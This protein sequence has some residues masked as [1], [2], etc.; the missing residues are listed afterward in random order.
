MNGLTMQTNDVGDTSMEMGGA[1]YLGKGD[2][3]D[4]GNGIAGIEL[5]STSGR[6]KTYRISFTDG[7]HYDYTV[8]DGATGATGQDG[9]DGADGVSV[10][11]AEINAQG[12][13]IITLSNGQQIDAGQVSGGGGGATWG[14]IT[15]DISDQTDL[16]NALNDK[17]D[18]DKLPLVIVYGA[19]DVYDAVNAA[20]TAHVPVFAKRGINQYTIAEK[21]SNDVFRFTCAMANSSRILTM[22]LK[23]DN[24]WSTAVEYLQQTSSTALITTDTTIVG[25]INEVATA[26]AD[27]PTIKTVMDAV[28]MT[29]TQYFLGT[30][31]AV[32]ITLPS[33]GISVGDEILVVFTSGATAATLICDLTGFDFTPKANKTSWL[34]FTCYDATNGDWLVETK[35]G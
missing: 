31:S 15:G 3:G 32:S 14:G 23:P 35:E 10:T 16:S 12:H 7:A 13:L 6:N 29:N 8:T 18:A 9:Q 26:K 21:G 33:T 27:K 22:L 28:A 30:Q 17:A 34:K 2:K 24:T 25:A 19:S 11:N 4:T 5:I 1:S 20:W